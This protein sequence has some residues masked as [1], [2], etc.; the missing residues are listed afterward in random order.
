MSGA[1]EGDRSIERTTPTA[2]P[3]GPPLPTW[4]VAEYAATWLADVQV[5]VKRHTYENY[6]LA[7]RN[8][9]VPTLGAVPLASVSRAQVADWLV[10]LRADGLAPSTAHLQLRVL[11]Y[12]LRSAEDRELITRN[13]AEHHRGASA[14]RHGPRQR[15]V[16]TPDE[17]EQFLAAVVRGWPHFHA[18]F[19]T[20]ART[21]LRL[22]E[23]R[24]LRWDDV[25]AEA[26]RIDVRRSGPEESTTKTDEDGT[27]GMSREVVC[28]LEALPRRGPWVFAGPHGT[29]WAEA[30]VQRVMHR[31][32]HLAG[33]PGRFT[34]HTLRH[35]FATTLCLRGVPLNIVQKALRHRGPAM[36][37]YYAAHVTRVPLATFEQLDRAHPQSGDVVATHSEPPRSSARVPPKANLPSIGRAAGPASPVPE[38][39][40]A[41]FLLRALLDQLHS[42]DLPTP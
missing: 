28:A 6:A 33:L 1:P 2:A 30:W 37:L 35:A 11:R 17:V 39:T 22:G 10:R 18:L 41:L 40:D 4:T 27:V 8:H 16:M 42:P 24:G 13:V 5:R 14:G 29:P 9:I 19:L 32:C 38:E 20:L 31:C 26:R 23:A 36:T 25:D 34:P 3:S 15:D 12:V 7:V 21:G